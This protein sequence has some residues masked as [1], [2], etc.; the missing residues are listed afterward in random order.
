M[1][2]PARLLMA[3]LLVC[4]A[5]ARAQVCTAAGAAPSLERQLRQL[6]LDLL[7]RP[8]TLDEYRDTQRKGAITEEDLRALMEREDFYARMKGYHRA[9]LRANVNSSV[10]LNGDTLLTA[11]TDGNRPLELRG[12]PG[13]PLRGKNGAGCAHAI[14]QDQCQTMH[15]DVHLETGVRRCRD[16]LGV[17]LPV[18][19]DYSTDQ[20]TCTA[21]AAA[22]C[23]DAMTQ[24][25]V[26]AKHFY[27]C[28]LRPQAAGAL[29]PYYCLP[30]LTNSVTAALTTE[31]LDSAGRVIAFSNPMPLPGQT[32]RLERC[33]TELKLRDGVRGRYLPQ[34]G[35]V[36][37]EGTVTVAT[38]PFWDASSAAVTLCAIEAQERD[39]NPWTQE[40]CETTR[41]LSDRSCGCGVRARRCEPASRVVHTARVAAINEEPLQ[42]ADSVLR[43]G[44][45]YFNTAHHAA[46][47]S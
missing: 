18:A 43:R 25:L 11:S 37:K 47:P 15:E 1:V 30:S 33:T 20:Y 26:P 41:F 12:N 44:E 4:A 16:E 17:P 8:P 5:P 21:L 22:S 27:Y 42:I 29:T 32:A 7:G 3:V 13:S 36:Q 9:L 40:S 38:A 23:A 46:G 24:G 6:S 35:C 31:E 45:D 28:D 39:L 34:A 14:E 19:V 10:F 2:R